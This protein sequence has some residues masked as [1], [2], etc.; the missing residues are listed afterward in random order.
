MIIKN[1][2]WDHSMGEVK[3]ALDSLSY[4]LKEG[5]TVGV[6]N[7]E[8]NKYELLKPFDSEKSFIL[9]ALTYDGT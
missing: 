3:E 2:G 8:T 5:V 4:W 6:F 1:C 7:E 9:V